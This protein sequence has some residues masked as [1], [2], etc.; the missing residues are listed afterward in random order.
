MIT[1]IE[2][3]G[4]WQEDKV[5]LN[6]AIS[7]LKRSMTDYKSLR[8]TEWKSFKRKFSDDLKDVEDSLKKLKADHKK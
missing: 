1:T 7:S 2:L 3:A 4:N 8:R 6:K 5:N